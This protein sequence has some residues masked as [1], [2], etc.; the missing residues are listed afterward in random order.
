MYIFDG[1]ISMENQ[2]ILEEYL[3]G[4]EYKTSGLSFPP[5]YVEISMISAEIIGDYMYQRISHLELEGIVL[6]FIFPPLTKTNTS[7]EVAGGHYEAQR[8]LKMQ[9]MSS[10]CALCLHMLD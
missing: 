9:V 7:S 6:P 4:Y 8:Y 1:K 10:V 2:T 3:K 5:I